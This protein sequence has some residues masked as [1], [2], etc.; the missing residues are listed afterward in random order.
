MRLP[1]AWWLLAPVTGT[2]FAVITVINASIYA[3][4]GV[5]TPDLRPAPS[6][7]AWAACWE[8]LGL[9]GLRLFRWA[10]LVDLAAFI[11]SYPPTLL[12][13]GLQWWASRAGEHSLLA[14]PARHWLVAAAA[15]AALAAGFLADMLEDVLLL[16]QLN[17]LPTVDADLASPAA[18]ATRTKFSGL[19]LYMLIVAGFGLVGLRRRK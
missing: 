17:M 9:D 18:H 15:A 16:R 5:R 11:P 2:A 10:L 14:V 8:G 19:A 13:A 7:A 6:P 12:L 3:E 1:G 4:T